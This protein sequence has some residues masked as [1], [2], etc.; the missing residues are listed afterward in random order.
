MRDAV[1]V[2]RDY[3]RSKSMRCT[4]ERDEIVR[5]L[6]TSKKHFRIEDLVK[7]LSAR[8]MVASRA[9]VYRTIP[10]LVQADL[11]RVAESTPGAE[12]TYEYVYGQEHHDHLFCVRCGRHIEFENDTIERLQEE[13]AGV[14]DF[15]LVGHRLDLYGVCRECSDKL[16]RGETPSLHHEI[17]P[18]EHTIE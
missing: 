15:I 16:E 17:Q 8:G 7:D 2:F 5:A 13:V 1:E 18:E 10:L 12:Y 6:A 14:N 9:T 3:L 11:V 4:S